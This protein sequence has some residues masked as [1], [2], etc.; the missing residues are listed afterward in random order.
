VQKLSIKKTIHQYWDFL[1]KCE[2]RGLAE[3]GVLVRAGM[4]EFEEKKKVEDA[5]YQEAVAAWGTSS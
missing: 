4:A 2:D 3:L 1:Q 5:K